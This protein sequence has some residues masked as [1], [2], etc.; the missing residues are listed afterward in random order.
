MNDH[1]PGTYIKLGCPGE[2]VPL[3]K[4]SHIGF[5][6][7]RGEKS[8]KCATSY[9]CGDHRQMAYSSSSAMGISSNTVVGNEGAK[10]NLQTG[11]CI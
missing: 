2:H 3:R 6:W 10:E 11:L 1:G 8:N 7:S 9:I 5:Y 4:H